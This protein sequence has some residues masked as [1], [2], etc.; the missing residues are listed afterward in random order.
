MN[1]LY[2]QA[3]DLIY[4]LEDAF[5]KNNPEIGND[6]GI[7]SSVTERLDRELNDSKTLSKDV[8]ASENATATTAGQVAETPNK[9][10]DEIDEK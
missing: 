10:E 2:S 4:E 3:T 9:I 7:V 6:S 8:R 1:D 5:R